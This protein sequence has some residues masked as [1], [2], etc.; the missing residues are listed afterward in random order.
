MAGPAEAA[1]RLALL[2]ALDVSSSVDD[3]EDRL[4]REGLAAALNSP[5]VREAMLGPGPVALG[6]FEWSGKWQQDWMLHWSVIETSAD[7]DAAIARLAA[8]QR[9]ETRYPTAI[10]YALSWAQRAF[11]TA[12]QCTYRT[13]DISGDGTNNDG[14]PPESTYKYFDYS[15]ITVNGLVIGGDPSV[16]LY[17]RDEVIRGPFAFV[18]QAENYADFER[19]M[20][21]KLLRELEPRA[22][23]WLR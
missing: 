9:V 1:C 19:A 5:V 23:G 2:L 3:A 17:Y 22:I 4:Q 6:V 10:G 13:L 14:Y 18:E 12:P 15:D 21:R 20:R 16:T 8:S 7:L 11:R